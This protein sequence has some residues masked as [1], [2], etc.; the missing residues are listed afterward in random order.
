VAHAFLRALGDQRAN[1]E[2]SPCAMLLGV[3]GLLVGGAYGWASWIYAY[4]RDGFMNDA[5][6]T[7]AHAYQYDNMQIATHTMSR[8]EV[9]DRTQATITKLSNYI[10]VTTLV[11]ALAAEMLVE[12][13]IPTMCADFVLNV[14]MLCLGSAMLYLVLSI[15][16]GVA[17]SNVI[18]E[19]SA[20]L[21]V[22]K[23]PPPWFII[24]RAMR[25]RED[26]ELTHAFE[27]KS[28]KEI[29]MPPLVRRTGV[30]KSMSR[31]WCRCRGRVE[32]DADAEEP[33]RARVPRRRTLPG[34]MSTVQGSEARSR[35]DYELSNMDGVEGGL[36]AIELE[37]DQTW[38][39]Y[40]RLWIPLLRQ[41]GM[42]A[43]LGV[44]NLLEAY[45]YLCMATLYGSFGSQAWAFWAVQIIF[46][47]L[48]LL[49]MQFMFSVE[50][51]WHTLLVVVGPVSCVIAAT[52]SWNWLD[53]V[54]VPLCY[55]SH[56]VQSFIIQDPSWSTRDPSEG[57]SDEDNHMPVHNAIAACS[58][59][60]ASTASKVDDLLSQVT[61]GQGLLCEVTE[62][63]P[64]HEHQFGQEPP[65]NEQSFGS[66]NISQSRLQR[67]STGIEARS[68]RKSMK[69]T[70]L[71]RH[72]MHRGRVVI[73]CL[74]TVSVGWACYK[75]IF[76]GK[77][78][79]S[80]APLQQPPPA[81]PP[82]AGLTVL[83]I[84][85][86]SPYFKPHAVVCPK[87]RV[88]LADRFRVFEITSDR[89]SVVPYPCNVDGR[90]ADIT[91]LCNATACWPIVLLEQSPKAV[92]D[93]STGQRYPLLQTDVFASRFAEH[94]NNTLIAAHNGQVVQYEWSKH[95]GG[96]APSW[97]VADVGASLDA[98]DAIG[99]FILLFRPG[100]V[101]VQDVSTGAICGVWEL[102]PKLSGAGCAMPGARAVLLLG[103]PE[104]VSEKFRPS[105]LHVMCAELGGEQCARPHTDLG[106]VAGESP[107]LSL[108]PRRKYSGPMR[109]DEATT[110]A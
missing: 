5:Q 84:T 17:A 96:W 29:F 65:R 100:S 76:D 63:Y 81:G 8:E 47:C 50:N 46:I 1:C 58:P 15:L 51:A 87:G 9:R 13:N 59:A 60:V 64:A 93:C 103:H 69:T 66:P 53:R 42:C 90:I 94:D 82:V 22:D 91:S 52:T 12:G 70:A 108:L 38:Y 31:F 86:P 85:S 39:E 74:W 3:A 44:K 72:L 83:A 24:D 37:Y 2:R 11:L 98:M 45:A 80:K 16:F 105:D 25:E 109:S 61:F 56:C 75:A 95:R 77:F 33:R 7:Q 79:N 48:N 71:V 34:Q 14:Y 99:R 30:M 6:V 101:E 106:S 67:Q 89:E 110:A 102:P 27:R 23:V 18:Y 68:A 32:G 41:S 43:G 20:D 21:L 35:Y 4:N 19:R 73:Q 36:H 92:L 40:T 26:E 55:M 97:V 49:I 104:S 88:F 107:C 54:L 62:Q 78:K 10:L 28:W 57:D